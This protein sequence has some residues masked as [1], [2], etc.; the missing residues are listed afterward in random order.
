MRNF[1]IL[2]VLLAFAMLAMPAPPTDA[3]P[4]TQSEFLAWDGPQ[5]TL[6]VTSNDAVV[7]PCTKARL[8][9]TATSVFD[10]SPAVNPTV[11]KAPQ[12]AQTGYSMA[13]MR[14]LSDSLA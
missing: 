2:I 1:L 6:Q 13:Y 7:E 12:Y 8:C 10:I 3:T 5:L 9:T 4:S 11:N 14:S